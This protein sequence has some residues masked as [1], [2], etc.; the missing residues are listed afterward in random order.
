MSTTGPAQT[1]P[2][3]DF[4][5]LFEAAP[6]LYLVLTPSLTIVA[7]SDAYLNAT[8]TTREQIL[9]RGIFDAFPDNPD[10]PHADGVRNL[11]ASLN[12]VLQDRA[13]D[14][15][16]VQK[17][18]IRRPASEGGGFE[19]RFW[20]PVNSPVF[21][22]N[23]ELLY[24]IHRV[25]DVTE[26][27]RLR[28]VGTEQQKLTDALRVKAEHMEAEIFAR[29]KQLEE[30]NRRRLESIGRL[31]GGVAHDFNNLLGVI[32]G[33][34]QLLE[35]HRTDPET[36]ARLL[37]QIK[38]A[39]ENAA[40]LTRQLLAYS[41]QQVLEPQ[42]L[43][44]NG[45]VQKIEPL[46]RR[47]IGDDIQIQSN[48]DPH[49][50]LA[51]ADPG[52]LEQVIMNLAINAR[53]AMPNGGR[54]FLET[55]NI[56]ADQ[57]YVSQHSTVTPGPYVMLSVSD[58]GSGMDSSTLDRIFE[59]FFTTKGR[60]RGTG[61]GLATVYGIVKQSGGYLWVY[62][63]LGLG[64]VF[65]IYLPRT[66]ESQALSIPPP[67]QSRA[68]RGSETVLLVEDQPLLR[69]V[70]ATMLQQDGYHVLSAEDPAQGL[71]LAR[72]HTGAIDLLITDI[73]MPGMNG[74][75]LA[76]QVELL[77]PGTKVLFVSGYAENI[78]SHH[79]Q[80]RVA[81]AFLQKPFT[82]ESLGRKVREVLNRP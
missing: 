35:D 82:C 64:T 33:C 68:A 22:K 48:L 10:D 65:K 11:R 26:F 69:K 40:S 76:E 43:S 41:L 77:R 15:M 17:Y 32:L 4:K 23:G 62:S 39:T 29:E 47:L 63:E 72:S 27:A 60:N 3:P 20:S 31:A 56:D 44:L 28:Q 46:L 52:Q 78:V 24:I 2:G 67:I 21:G 49:L 70:V 36:T 57:A 38:Q 42:L 25:E 81:D 30:A 14:P 74:P 13:S 5:A 8:M 71:E 12:R 19:E 80:L 51:K 66:A 18:D 75:V 7:V 34:A 61:L 45:V 55:S 37:N 53:D 79:G 16:P 59:P 58:T 73:I 6:G 54:L 9:G 50:G 1:F